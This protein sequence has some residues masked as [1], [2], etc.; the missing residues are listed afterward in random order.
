MGFG[1]E[2]GYAEN[3]S[4]DEGTSKAGVRTILHWEGDEF[5]TQRQQDMEPVLAYVK[6]RREQLA[7]Q[8]WGEGREVGHIPELY[9]PQIAAITDRDQRREAVKQFFA[10]HPQF[11]FYENYLK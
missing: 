2:K 11:C 8:P 10:D 7:G 5:I 6:A 9:Y 1:K 4:L 3:L